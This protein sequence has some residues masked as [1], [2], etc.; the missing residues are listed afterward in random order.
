[1]DIPGLWNLL[2]FRPL[3]CSCF[4]VQ[5]S[6]LICFS[7]FLKLLFLKRAE[8]LEYVIYADYYLKIFIIYTLTLH[9]KVLCFPIFTRWLPSWGSEWEHLYT[10]AVSV[11]NHS[12]QAAAV[13]KTLLG[14]GKVQAAAAGKTLFALGKVEFTWRK[15][16]FS[17][18]LR[19][20]CYCS[21]MRTSPAWEMLTGILWFFVC[22]KTFTFICG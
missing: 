11:K 15:T 13:G 3:V 14:L 4:H 20:E 9:R 6:K 5:N 17:V 19:D 2:F 1:M 8:C 22:F 21:V 7:F 12:G 10:V 16:V 18:I